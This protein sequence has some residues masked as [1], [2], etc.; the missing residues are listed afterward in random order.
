MRLFM[1]F[2]ALVISAAAG[3]G[4]WLATSQE[5]ADVVKTVEGAPDVEVKETSV[6][7]ARRDIP[8]GHKITADDLDRQTWPAS[9]VIPDF[10][11]AGGESQLIDRVARTNFKERQPLMLSFL[12]NPNDPGFLA[13][14]LPAGKRAI[15]LPIDDVSGISGFVFPGDRVDIIVKHRVGLNQ[16]YDDGSDQGGVPQ[17]EGA[18]AM[19]PKKVTA[20]PLPMAS[21]YNVPT[22][23]APSKL[24]GQPIMNVTEVLVSNVRVLA[25]GTISAQYTQEANTSPRTITIEV[26]ELQAQKLRHADRDSL[27]LSLRSLEDVNNN[28]TTRPVGDSDMSRLIPPSYFPHLYEEGGNYKSEIVSLGEIDYAAQENAPK[29]KDDSTVTIIRGIKKEIVGVNRP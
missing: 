21:S 11:Q 22:L 19:A 14:Q 6:L 17:A 9:L 12:A 18:A 5:P 8:V 16:D 1:I 20:V 26:T 24:D 10:V 15:T 25:L 3:I 2:I 28:E 23:M 29:N 13:A 4:F 7:V 27:T